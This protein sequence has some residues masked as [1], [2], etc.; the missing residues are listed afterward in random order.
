MQDGC[1]EKPIS[2][3]GKKAGKSTIVRKVILGISGRQLKLV[4]SRF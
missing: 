4:K 2:H 1:R 3:R